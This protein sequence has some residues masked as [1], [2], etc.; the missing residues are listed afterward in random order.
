MS[1]FSKIFSL[2]FLKNIFSSRAPANF[3]SGYFKIHVYFSYLFEAIQWSVLSA[4]LHQALSFG[5][6]QDL[7]FER[8]KLS[9]FGRKPVPSSRTDVS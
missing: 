6:V 1:S 4:N 5:E 8:S 3:S 9:H 2:S 7:H